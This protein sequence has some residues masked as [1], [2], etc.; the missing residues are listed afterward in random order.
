MERY[1]AK[2]LRINLNNREVKEETVPENITMNLIG[3]RGYGVYYLYK[4]LRPGIDPLGESNKLIVLTGV[5]AGTSAQ[6]VARWMVCTKSPLTGGFARSVAGGDFGAWLKFTGY[7]FLIIEGK[8]STPVYLHLTPEGCQIMEANEIWGKNTKETTLQLTEIHGNRTRIASIGPA[9][10]KMVR[11]ASIITG[12]RAAGRCG[13]GAV[14]GSKNLKAIAIT[15][16]WNVK[17]HDK[18]TFK[19]LVKDQVAAYRDNPNYLKHKA[20]GTTYGQNG[21][22]LLGVFP[23]RNFRLGKMEEPEKISGDEYREI[24]TGD[25]GCYSCSAKCAKA[26]CA[27]KGIYAGIQADAGPEYETIWAFTGTIDSTEIGASVMADQMCDEL[28]MDT[29]STGNTIGFAYELY[30]KGILTRQ[31]TDGIE[32]TY[33]NH[34]AMIAL[35]SKIAAREGIGNLLAEGTKR[36]AETLGQGTSDFAINVKGLELPA[37]DPRGL[38]TMGLNFA[39]SNIGASHCYGYAPQEIFNVPV[40][41]K[42]DRFD[43]V[44][45]ADLAIYNQNWRG[46][47]ETG[48]I[49]T[50]SSSWGWFPKIFSQMLVAVTGIEKFG[51]L[52]YLNLVGERVLNMERLFN[53]REGFGRKDDTLP[54]RMLTETLDTGD[55]EG[56]GREVVQYLE[57]SLDRYYSLRGWTSEGVPSEQKLK[58]LGLDVLLDI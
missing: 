26:T 20:N 54:K 32:L 53:V 17:L 16:Q 9:G 11:Y 45:N 5:L 44:E 52:D 4:E 25:I 35:I 6:S 12:G 49:C 23:L 10:E 36:M 57:E 30:E 18:V 56:K 50:F 13:V 1:N 24:R 7:E 14:M 48:I 47:A 43:E 38:K 8:A 21:T 33:G 29:I 19:Q 55:P 51:D 46:F 15:A 28:G 34:E 58:E 3:G 41:R 39:T 37:Y 27:N 22:N 42:I 31:D 2:F 40:P